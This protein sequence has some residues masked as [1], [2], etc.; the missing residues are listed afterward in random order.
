MA[1]GGR[2]LGIRIG[3]MRWEEDRGSDNWNRVLTLQRGHLWDE[4]EI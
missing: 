1:F 2:G 3:G 4:L